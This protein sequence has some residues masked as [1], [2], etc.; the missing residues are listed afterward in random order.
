MDGIDKL[1]K[2]S[3]NEKEKLNISQNILKKM[4]TQNNDKKTKISDKKL[5][6]EINNQEEECI[7]NNEFIDNIKQKT[8][9]KKVKKFKYPFRSSYI[10]SPFYHKSIDQEQEE[11]TKTDNNYFYSDDIYQKKVKKHEEIEKD[12]ADPCFVTGSKVLHKGLKIEF[13][14]ITKDNDSNTCVLMNNETNEL[15]WF[16]ECELQL[17]NS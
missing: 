17:V 13:D 11:V 4:E 2:I 6:K 10:N 8:N 1:S 5:V 15:F 16:K 9:N 7:T 3:G 14:F 12:Q